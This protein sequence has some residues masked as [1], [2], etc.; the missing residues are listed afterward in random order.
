MELKRLKRLLLSCVIINCFNI[1]GMWMIFSVKMILQIVLKFKKIK[2]I[3]IC[4]EK[5]VEKIFPIKKKSD[6]NWKENE[7]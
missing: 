4:F 6:K 3:K 5:F 2:L 7:I 1:V